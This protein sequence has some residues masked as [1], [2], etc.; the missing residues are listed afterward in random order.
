[1]CMRCTQA[2]VTPGTSSAYGSFGKAS[3]LGTIGTKGVRITTRS[4]QGD[5][6]PTGWNRGL[7]FGFQQGRQ[8]QLDTLGQRDEVVSPFEDAD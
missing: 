1:M 3:A 5:G 8:V 4:G 6:V 7:A 2:D